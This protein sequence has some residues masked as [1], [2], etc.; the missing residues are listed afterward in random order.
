MP[1]N[2][3]VFDKSGFKS[4]ILGITGFQDQDVSWSDSPQ[5]AVSYTDNAKVFLTLR[6]IVAL[7]V[8]DH[9][10]A[11][12]PP[13][14]PANSYVTTELGNRDCHLS[15]RAESYS[16]ELAAVEILDRIRSAIRWDSNVAAL[17][18]LNLAFVWAGPA[19]HVHTEYDNRVVSAGV[20]DM[21]IAGVTFETSSVTQGGD[22]IATVNTNNTVPGNLAQP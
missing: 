1:S 4:I 20:M 18:A 2:A 5:G 8:D 9:R 22:W 7:G 16:R 13:D 3:R 15:I 17:N 12:N 10:Y 21:T 11:Y 19:I 6:S 14:Y